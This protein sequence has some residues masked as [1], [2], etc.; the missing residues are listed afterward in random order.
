M[1]DY[2][3]VYLLISA[4][5]IRWWYFHLMPRYVKFYMSNESEECHF[6]NVKTGTIHS[7]VIIEFKEDSPFYKANKKTIL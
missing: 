2:I 1:R 4:L 7:Q 6:Q 3:E 5:K